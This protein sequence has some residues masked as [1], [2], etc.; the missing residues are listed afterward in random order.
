MDEKKL[1]TG[2]FQVK[3]I[4]GNMRCRVLLK[5]GLPEKHLQHITIEKYIFSELNRWIFQISL[6][7]IN[8]SKN[9]VYTGIMQF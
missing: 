2:E 4:G 5:K 8:Y 6:K 9:T 7:Y 3:G 1:H